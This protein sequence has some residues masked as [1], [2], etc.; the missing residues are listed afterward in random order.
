M[1]KEFNTPCTIFDFSIIVIKNLN[2]NWSIMI[3][4]VL[5]NCPNKLQNSIEA[6]NSGRVGIGYCEFSFPV[7]RI[8]KYI[9]YW[10]YN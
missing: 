2:Q 6:S 10:N 5:E 8:I 1:W 9:N 3:H 7:Y 4:D